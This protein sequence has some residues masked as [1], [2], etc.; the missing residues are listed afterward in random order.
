MFAFERKKVVLSSSLNKPI[1]FPGQSVACSWLERCRQSQETSASL[2]RRSR[3]LWR[4]RAR[5]S[6]GCSESTAS[7]T[8][9]CSHQSTDSRTKRS[10]TGAP[11]VDIH[12]CS[13]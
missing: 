10:T 5:L 13:W 11:P 3:R 4:Q 12:H 9:S 6:K 1:S 8:H 2:S 7:H